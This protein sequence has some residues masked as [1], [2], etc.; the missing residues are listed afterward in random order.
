MGKYHKL[1]RCLKTIGWKCNFQSIGASRIWSL[2]KL[3]P[4]SLRWKKQLES[5]I[6][7]RMTSMDKFKE[8]IKVSYLTNINDGF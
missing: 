8:I 3:R 2:A 6:Y 1:Q 7:L 5:N 4:P